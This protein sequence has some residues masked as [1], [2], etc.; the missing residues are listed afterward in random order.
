MYAKHIL[1]RVKS[2]SSKLWRP[3]HQSSHTLFLSSIKYAILTFME[4]TTPKVTRVLILGVHK[5]VEAKVRSVAAFGD[6][7]ALL[8]L[9]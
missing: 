1:K 5:L 4:D 8:L 9:L 3:R 7:F 2:T 6:G